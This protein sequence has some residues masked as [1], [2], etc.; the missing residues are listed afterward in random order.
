MDEQQ[1]LIELNER[2]KKIAAE[3]AGLHRSIERLLKQV[4]PKRPEEDRI[5]PGSP[6][7]A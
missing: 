5:D 6:E 4:E 7:G 2:I 3:I 1:S